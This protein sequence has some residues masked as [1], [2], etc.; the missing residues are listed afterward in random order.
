MYTVYVTTVFWLCGNFL[1][2]LRPVGKLEA[3][4]I[5]LVEY[6]AKIYQESCAVVMK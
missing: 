6:R 5:L 1:W 3:L 4:K 2:K